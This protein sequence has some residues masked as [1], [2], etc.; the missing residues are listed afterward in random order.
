MKELVKIEGLKWIRTY[1]MFPNSV[2]DELI[3]VM[4]TEEKICNYFDI[5]I[6]H[7][8][9]SMLQGMKR[10]I[11]GEASKELLR[12]I[13]REIPDATFRTSIIVGFPGET[14]DDF[15]ELKEFVKEFKFD[16]IG[17]FKYSREEDT[18][19]F[20]MENQVDEDVK[21]RRWVELSNLQAEIV[22]IKNRSFLGK[23]IE[24]MIDGVSE[25]SEYMLEGR[26]RG[27]ALEIDGKVLTNDGTAKP[28]EIVKVMIE[29]NFNYDLLGPIVMNESN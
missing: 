4:K 26:T 24:V 2:T 5:P 3:E 6:Q 28:G 21:H 18:V 9:D 29:Q 22:E 23:E 20:D 16:Y 27:Q 12:R 15:E 25:E 8:S 7:V 11:S 19:A 13:R 17:V 14:E 10:A 1:Y